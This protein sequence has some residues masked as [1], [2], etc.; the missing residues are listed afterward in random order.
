MDQAAQE[1]EATVIL[2]RESPTLNIRLVAR[3]K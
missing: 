1:E 2:A 3:L